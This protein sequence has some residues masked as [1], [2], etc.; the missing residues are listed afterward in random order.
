MAKPEWGAKRICHNCGARFYD[1][2]RESIA[3]PKC[4]TA[5]D[6]EALL[7]SRRSRSPVVAEIAAAK[8]PKSKA[9]L[10]VTASE[11]GLGEFE[12]ADLPADE[13]AAEDDGDIE[14]ISG[15]EDFEEEEEGDDAAASGVLLEDASELGDDDV[16]DVIPMGGDDEEGR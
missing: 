9:P 7:K 6:P 13:M 4:G 3:C 10:D 15:D 2:R 8:T 16:D 11:E 14:S 5:F 12:E 1:M